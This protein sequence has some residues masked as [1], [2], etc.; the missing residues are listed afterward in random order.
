M[1]EG[2][3][4]FSFGAKPAAKPNAAAGP[5][6]LELLMAKA[7]GG[8]QAKPKPPVL[9]DDD[10]ETSTR[11]PPSLFA[12]KSTAT[13][14]NGPPP[15][16]QMSRAERKAREEA[17]KIDQSVFDYDGVYDQ[18]KAAERQTEQAR[19][20]A[21]DTSRPRYMESFLAAAET[22]RLDRL[23]A[24]EKMLERERQSEGEEFADKEKFVTEAYKRQMEEVRKAEEEEKAREGEDLFWA[25]L[26]AA[27]A[28][29]GAKGPG[30]TSL[31]KTMLDDN[32]AR[33]E[34]A[35]AATST[36]GPSLAIR[37]P[38]QVDE[39]E[40]DPLLA[41]QAGEAPA[42]LRKQYSA[43]TYAIE[44]DTGKEVE[45]NDDG[46]IVNKR[47]LLRAGL[48]ITKKPGPSL[49]ASLLSGSGQRSEVD[50]S[51]PYVSRAVGAAASY[52]ER[53]AREKKRL[54]EQIKEQEEKKRREAEERRR[55]EEEA[56]RKRRE[57][58]DG[59]AERRRQE[60]KERF[61]ARKRQR[62]EEAQAKK[63]AKVE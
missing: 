33:H 41:R 7:K 36:A 62:E 58:D 18:L 48:N 55:E 17:M 50:P 52:Q 29:K 5:S 32:A 4:S 10:E 23:R 35:M 9:F 59:S 19:E 42:G 39:E 11:P 14:T 22:R 26:I 16:S 30:L 54:A 40:Y 51:K 44:Q 2:K 49:P 61:L 45:V 34:A 28:R 20:A 27:A 15:V 6:N 46:E 8:A 31:Y 3:L 13:K 57:G 60:A 38:T 63:K 21:N 56:A 47:S 24:E 12:S 37:P 53:M 25:S 1:S 43:G